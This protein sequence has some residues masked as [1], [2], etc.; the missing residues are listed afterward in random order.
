MAS[1]FYEQLSHEGKV[2]VDQAMANLEP[3]YDSQAGLIARVY[4]GR[5]FYHHR[6]S[7]YYALGLMLKGEEGCAQEVEKICRAV[8]GL[9][10]DAPNEIFHGAYLNPGR[11]PVV[12]GALDYKR[13]GLYGRYYMDT[14]YEKMADHFR[15]HL[16]DDPD[17]APFAGKI[18]QL[19]NQSTVETVPLVWTT[20]DPNMR[21]FNLMSF[22]MLLEHF[23][24]QLSEEC[25]QVIDH[26]CRLALEG[27]VNRS[28]SGFTP[29]NTNIQCM[30]VFLVDYF[31]VRW[32]RP[33]LCEYAMEF[34]HKMLDKYLNFHAAAEFNSPT[35]CGVDLATLGFWR[36][37]ASNDKL[38]EMGRILEDG[39]WMDMMDF[40]N[41]AMVNFC[42]PYSR[43]YEP[44][45]AFHT[46]FHAMFYLAAGE[47]KFP[48][49]PVNFETP[50][51]ML[52]V[53]GGINMP[54]EAK[55]ALFRE[56]KD[57]LIYRQFRELSERGDPEHNDALCTATAWISPDMMTGALAGSENPSHQLHPL[58]IFWRGEK[59]L[60]TIKLLRSYPNGDMQHMHTVLFNGKADRNHLTMNVDF[61][62]NRDVK[63]FYEIEY[64]G[65][66]DS[67]EITD[68]LWKLPGMQLHMDAK[69]PAFQLEKSADGNSLKVCYISR[70]RVP[71][72]KQ[73][74]FDM[75]AELVK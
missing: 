67:A 56:K 57:H 42:G 44:D 33:D 2:L 66:C 46:C 7:M 48:L 47:E 21:E 70:A 26:T 19:L 23:S 18:E 51:D 38:K 35:Y 54:E 28:K 34:A 59:G 50:C 8:A 27:A 52:M 22:A 64:P 49:H 68:T 24:D 15:L 75:T 60:G 45:M 55:D 36:R 1:A 11:P 39:I 14:F 37:Y 65:I 17:L 71:E 63:L 30:H 31:G 9:Q 74:F 12:H 72:T 62:V 69:A 61:Q 32:N 53:F 58:V 5:K 10:Q 13:L 43:A 29:L 4:G 41:P 73:M 20:Y 6:F 3:C 16:E 25:I 40:Y